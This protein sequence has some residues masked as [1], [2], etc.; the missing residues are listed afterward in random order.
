MKKPGRAEMASAPGGAARRA[1]SRPLSAS[2]GSPDIF[3]ASF[4]TCRAAANAD[5]S[6]GITDLLRLL[7]CWGQCSPRSPDLV[8]NLV[9]VNERPRQKRGF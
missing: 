6:V 8:C 1:T 2:G 9:A 3:Q 7:V 4:S 5:G